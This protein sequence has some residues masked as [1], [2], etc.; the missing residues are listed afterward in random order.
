MADLGVLGLD[1]RLINALEEE[2][3]IVTIADLVQCKSTDLLSIPNFGQKCLQAVLD[4]LPRMDLIEELAAQREQRFQDLL[5]G[6]ERSYCP[7]EE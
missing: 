6:I 2:R 7:D 5:S 4:C 1:V 3:C